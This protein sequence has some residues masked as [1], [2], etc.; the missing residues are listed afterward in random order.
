MTKYRIYIILISVICSLPAIAQ[1]K[2]EREHR[3]RKSQF[4]E[5]ALQFIYN[6]LEEARRIR[7]YKE[8]DSTKT[9][10]EAKFKKDRLHYSAEFDEDGSLE[11]IEIMI[12]EVDI[13]NDTMSSI[14]EDLEKRFRSYRIRKIQQQYPVTSAEP[15]KTTLRNAFQNLLIPSLRYELIVAGKEGK[16]FKDFD[17]VYTAGGSFIS[18]RTSL[19]ANYDHVLY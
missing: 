18:I 19:P 11:N 17:I 9:S 4:P 7:F 6:T 5:K 13:P 8:T 14:N 15:S 12:K 2:Y 1:N 3:V 10:Y 16:S